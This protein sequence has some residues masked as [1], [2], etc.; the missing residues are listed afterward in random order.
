M[1][2]L[3]DADTSCSPYLQGDHFSGGFGLAS[4]NDV[5]LRLEELLRFT[6]AE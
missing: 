1:I 4:T 2:R 3:D 6:V 5:A